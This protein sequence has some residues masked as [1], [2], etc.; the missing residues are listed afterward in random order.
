MSGGF[1]REVLTKGKPYRYVQRNVA[2]REEESAW[3]L[4]V[5]WQQ[6]SSRST[7]DP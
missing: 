3:L 7:R 1:V 5:T 6:Q 4:R 2:V